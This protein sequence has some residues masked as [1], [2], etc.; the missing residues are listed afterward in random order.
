MNIFYL[1]N[2]QAKDAKKL[3]SDVMITCNFSRYESKIS[4]EG[5]KTYNL[6]INEAINPIKNLIYLIKLI[7]II[8]SLNLT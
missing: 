7:K 8:K 1:I 4:S 5:F 3:M 2:F 6:K